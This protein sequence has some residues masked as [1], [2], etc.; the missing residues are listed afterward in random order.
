MGNV[1][2][3]FRERIFEAFP[4]SLLAVIGDKGVDE[5]VKLMWDFY[6]IRKEEIAVRYI[7]Y[8]DSFFI[9]TLMDDQVF[10]VDTVELTLKRWNIPYRAVVH[11]IIPAVRDNNG[12]L[13]DIDDDKGSLES[14]IHVEILPGVEEDRIKKCVSAL[15]SILSMTKAMV[16]DFVKMKKKVKDAVNDIEFLADAGKL[17]RED[18]SEY[19]LFLE[20][21]IDDN[22]VFFGYGKALE[23][24]GEIEFVNEKGLGVLRESLL[25]DTFLDFEEIRETLKKAKDIVFMDK[26]SID[27]PIHRSG[28]IDIL[29]SRIVSEEGEFIG[30]SYWVGLLTKKA[31]SSKGGDVPLLRRK[32]VEILSRRNVVYAS[33]DYKRI[34]EIFNSIPMEDLLLSSVEEI[35]EVIDIVMEMGLE[36]EISVAIRRKKK[37]LISVLV[38]LPEEKFSMAVSDSIKQLLMK[39]FEADYVDERFSIYEE[40][41]AFLYFFLTPQKDVYIIDPDEIKAEIEKLTADWDD[42]FRDA[43]KENFPDSW[44]HLFVKYAPSFP[45]DYK[46]TVSASE[47]VEDVKFLEEVFEH[48]SIKV[49]IYE[50]EGFSFIKIYSHEELK[51][52][53]VVPILENFYLSIWDEKP[54]EIEFP[55]GDKHYL[56][57]YRVLTKENELIEEKTYDKLSDAIIAVMNRVVE[58]DPLNNL[59]IK[60]DF[61]WKSVDVLRTYRNYIRQIVPSIAY[62]TAYSAFRSYPDITRLLWDYFDTKFNP[63][64]GFSH[65]ERA[66]KLEDIEERYYDSL[67]QVFSISEDK[68]FRTYFNAIKSTIRTNYYKRNKKCHY[69]SIKI[70]C[71]SIAEMP[72]PRPMYE[73]Y[74][75]ER[76]VEGVHLRGGKI[77]RGGIRWSDR[78]DDFRTEILGLMKTQMIKNAIIVPT[79]A[80]GGFII[81][82]RYYNVKDRE[83]V[84]RLVKEKYSIFI[85]GLL[86]LTDNIVDGE[87]ISPSDVIRY[88]DDDPYLVVA[89]DKGTARLSDVANSI[90]REYN[91]WLDDAFASGGST[92]YDHK[93]MGVTAK[94]AWVCV[95]RHFME[96]G[97]NP[98]EDVITVVGI[99]DMSG[100]VFG[101]GLLRSRTVKLI[102]A[103]N[104]R[105]IFLDPDPDPEKS[106]QERLRLFREVKDWDHYNPDLISTGGGVFRR[107][108]KEIRLSPEA[109]RALSTDKDVV[110]GEELI[111]IIL[112]ADVDL[113]WN[114]GIGTYVKASFESHAEVGDPPN[115]N[116][117]VDAKDLRVKVV[118]EGGNLGFTQKAR[119]E[120]AL[121]GGRINMDAIDNSGGVDTSDHEVNIKILLSTPVKK[122]ELSWDERNKL[123]FDIA[124]EVLE[125]V[126]KDNYSQSLS[127]S[128][129]VLRSKEDIDPFIDTIG[130]LIDD[131]LID[132][133]E[134]YLPK[135]KELKSRWE[136]GLGLLRPELAMLIGYEKRWVKEKLRGSSLLKAS[137]LD[138]YLY[139]YFPKTIRERFAEYIPSHP[140]RDEIVLT[141][142]VNSI[143]DQAGI[144]FF[145]KM[146][147]DHGAKVEE[148]TASYVMMDGILDA[149]NLRERIYSLDFK[150]DAH[151]QYKALLDIENTIEEL[152]KWSHFFVGD[153]LPLKNVVEKYCDEI[154]KLKASIVALLSDHEKEEFIKRKEFYAK[155][156]FPDDLASDIAVIPFLSNAMD[157]ITL[158]EAVEMDPLMLSG[159]YFTISHKFGID[160]VEEAIVKEE[161]LSKWDHLA[162]SLLHRDLYRVR[163][164][165]VERF[166]KFMRDKNKDVD[167]FMAKEIHHWEEIRRLMDEA[168]KEKAKGPSVWYVIIR[169]MREIIL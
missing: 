135:K 98:E 142:I 87:V 52:S 99:G 5:R 9:E 114:G 50:K 91:F 63:E 89:A 55:S 20:W 158:S 97:V 93:K 134:V 161:R 16:E 28:K 156:G 3:K 86:D 96:M 152:V 77:A 61:D 104:H 160:E 41:I 144:S 49:A 136:K 51:L 150:V 85:R 19:A 82:L 7:R 129:D 34:V 71:K 44:E 157:I 2:E 103:F 155:S 130:R 126:L 11:P 121:N 21:I 57:I 66:S 164:A 127:I 145:T 22:F 76:G 119:V 90:A 88:D 30:W 154:K 64:L 116:V 131:G 165:L 8:K 69:I 81:K 73:I 10:L 110:S 153:W 123:I 108:A 79:G 62:S 162:Y 137:Y 94:G 60:A 4:R 83:D 106:Y 37:G 147:R 48:K 75:H 112:K 59:V 78:P 107:D 128:L 13:L 115:D 109:K 67:S 39:K 18:A 68:V 33:H 100:D 56:H 80:K 133:Q 124:D 38:L 45:M 84:E 118:G 140:L 125:S 47:A 167:E 35:D 163:R 105:V 6:K 139:N 138:D 42:L 117:R 120:Y 29:A 149:C 26:L 113:L 132:P 168:K 25:K 27:S 65:E 36:K 102:A 23:K 31:I 95:K 141:C 169:R 17:S 43:L 92:G 122:G 12:E 159:I 14:F 101:N 1:M 46:A 151:V 24:D 146:E 111:K 74:V 54:F 148:V 72:L 70:D 166:I 32:L 58:S 15:K 53:D 143:V 40:A